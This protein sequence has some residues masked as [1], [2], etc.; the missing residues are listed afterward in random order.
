MPITN[1]I[2]H[3]FEAN[4]KEEVASVNILDE[5]VGSGESKTYKLL[6]TVDASY[7]SVAALDKKD[8]KF[9]GLEV[10]RFS[11]P[12]TSKQLSESILS[13]G[14]QSSL[15]KKVNFDKVSVQISGNHYAFIPSILFR[16]ENAGQFYS[17]GHRKDAQSRIESENVSGFDMVNV[18]SIDEQVFSSLKTVFNNFL[19]HHHITSLL[20]AVRLQPVKDGSR[21]LFIHFRAEWVDVIVT[22]G[23]KLVLCNSFNYKSVEDA[24]YFTL[25]ICEQLGL[26]PSSVETVLMGGIEKDSTLA[27]LLSKYVANVHYSERI[28]AAK[29]TYGF[30]KLASHFYYSVFSHILCES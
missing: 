21:K 29:F 24:V 6:C 16:K 7:I 25:N 19:P 10:F 9:V 13:L 11:K 17:V 15:L 27:K 4:P 20:A 12:C 3:L 30:D 18:F 26:N 23:R 28:N 5:S 14:K 2:D 22:E 1:S 8:S